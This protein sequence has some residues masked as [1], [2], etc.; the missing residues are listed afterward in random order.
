M[1]DFFEHE[2]WMSCVLFFFNHFRHVSPVSCTTTGHLTFVFVCDFVSRVLEVS[3]QTSLECRCFYKLVTTRVTQ[4]LTS[5]FAKLLMLQ[6]SGG[7]NS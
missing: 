1:V 4:N 2:F 5:G 6:K 7:C 3:E